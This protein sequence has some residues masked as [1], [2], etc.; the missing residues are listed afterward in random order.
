MR[1]REPL[2]D[3]GAVRDSVHGEPGH[4]ERGP[5][6]LDVGDRIRGGVEPPVRPDG[7]RARADRGGAG[8]VRSD[9]PICRCSAGQSS[10]PAPVPRWSNITSR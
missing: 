2:R 9:A 3:V 5:Q 1:Q 10:A 7:R 8:T 6:R 4:A